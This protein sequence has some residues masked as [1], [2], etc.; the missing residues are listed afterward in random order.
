[1]TQPKPFVCW[2]NPD[3]P[4]H[5]NPIFKWP[6]CKEP[7]CQAAPPYHERVQYVPDDLHL[8]IY[9]P[10][11][12]AGTTNIMPR[13]AA[14]GHP[15][16]DGRSLVY[17]EGWIHGAPTAAVTP[18]EQWEAGLFQAADRMITRYPT[19]ALALMNVDL[20]T[21]VGTY[22]PKTHTYEITDEET[23]TAWIESSD[24]PGQKEA[25]R[26]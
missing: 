18:R 5:E 22:H 25:L 13:S 12:M 2:R 11:G 1:M 3:H 8:P 10:T 14:V 4:V 24:W 20:M 19:T 7:N 26:V 21:Q 6:Q 15:P 23:L 16:R 17:Y 9:V